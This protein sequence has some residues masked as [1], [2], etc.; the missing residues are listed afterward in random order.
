MKQSFFKHYFGNSF[1]IVITLTI[2]LML[3]GFNISEGFS[4]LSFIIKFSLNSFLI[5]VLGI[6]MFK[7]YKS[8]KDNN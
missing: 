2:I 6:N 4:D 7:D 3:L 1:N 5:L 8:Y